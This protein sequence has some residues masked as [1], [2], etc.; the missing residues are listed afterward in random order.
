VPFTVAGA[1]VAPKGQASYDEIVAAA[2]DLAF[3]NGFE[4]M[5]WFLK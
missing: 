2:S 4:L 1:G 3:T 5:P